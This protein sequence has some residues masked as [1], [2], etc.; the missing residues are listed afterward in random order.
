[1]S[2]KDE[3][4]VQSAMD[5][6]LLSKRFLAYIFWYCGRRSAFHCRSC[7]RE[8]PTT[9]A[10]ARTSAATK[11]MGR[12]W[13]VHTAFTRVGSLLIYTFSL[14]RSVGSFRFA[15]VYVSSCILPAGLSF[16]L[17]TNTDLQ[18]SLHFSTPQWWCH[19]LL[20]KTNFIPLSWQKRNASM[21]RPLAP[22]Y[23]YLH[24]VRLTLQTTGITVGSWQHFA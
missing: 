18:L 2:T 15:P 16:S 14:D 20:L 19:R 13:Y 9:D 24:K 1:M 6:L 5:T 11:D 7:C 12:A 3:A 4:S 21:L 22:T 8:V 23:D 10:C 17:I